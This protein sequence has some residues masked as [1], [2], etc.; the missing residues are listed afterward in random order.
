MSKFKAGNKVRAKFNDAWGDEPMTVIQIAGDGFYSVEH[1]TNGLGA[2]KE[3]NLELWTP[4]Q[5][6]I[7]NVTG[8]NGQWTETFDDVT[9]RTLLNMQLIVHVKTDIYDDH[10]VK[11]YSHKDAGIY[12]VIDNRNPDA[13]RQEFPQE[14]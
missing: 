10:I 1:P 11:S 9:I 8:R 14:K 12:R 6:V 7:H 4:E 2:F 3:G 13:L 5:K